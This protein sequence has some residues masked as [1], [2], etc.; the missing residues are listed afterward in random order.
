MYNDIKMRVCRFP[1][2]VCDKHTWFSRRIPGTIPGMGSVQ[3]YFCLL[4]CSYSAFHPQ[5]RTHYLPITIG[6]I[7]SHMVIFIHY[8]YTY[9]FVLFVFIIEDT[10]CMPNHLDASL[11]STPLR[12][13]SRRLM[14]SPWLNL[15][16]HRV[17]KK[18]G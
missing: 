3:L 12:W 10:P 2:D 7:Q 17:S 6:R 16:N 14:I 9:F 1:Y 18:S 15:S 8:L 4:L 5:A 13:G 11:L